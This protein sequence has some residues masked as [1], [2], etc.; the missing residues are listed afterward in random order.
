MVQ[1]IAKCIGGVKIV[2]RE[3]ERARGCGR[4]GV[5]QCRL[6]DLVFFGAGTNKTAAIGDEHTYFWTKIKP[7]AQVR[8][9]LPHNVVRDDGVDLYRGYVLAPGRQRPGDVRTAA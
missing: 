8:E 1:V 5:H 6:Q 2:L 3:C 4:P 7:P 9:T